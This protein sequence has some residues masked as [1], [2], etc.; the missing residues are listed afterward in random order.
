MEGTPKEIQCKPVHI[1]AML[2]ISSSSKREDIYHESAIYQ[3][4]MWY[5]E[6]HA[7]SQ[8]EDTRHTFLKLPLQE[9]QEVYMFKALLYPFNKQAAMAKAASDCLVLR[10]LKL[11]KGGIPHAQHK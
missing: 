11:A 3:R 9:L 5:T 2:P 8:G 4:C 1:C 6:H 7:V 10:T